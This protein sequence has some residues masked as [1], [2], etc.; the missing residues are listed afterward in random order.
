MQQ[1]TQHVLVF[2]L[3]FLFSIMRAEKLS[4]S[5][6]KAFFSNWL[7]S[8]QVKWIQS[9]DGLGWPG[10]DPPA[11]QKSIAFPFSWKHTRHCR[12]VAYTPYIV[13]CRPIVE[14]LIDR[15]LTLSLS[16]SRN[17]LECDVRWHFA[18][19]LPSSFETMRRPFASGARR[20]PQKKSPFDW[21]YWQLARTATA[22]KSQTSR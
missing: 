21:R 8:P 16:H 13:C 3:R 20:S 2:F 7:F 5:M 10:L 14:G 15:S 18:T 22:G 17:A 19:A 11:T 4:T 12:I 1:T 6:G 9:P